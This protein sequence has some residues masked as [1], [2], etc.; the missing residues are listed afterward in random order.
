MSVN[1]TEE[2]RNLSDLLWN[3]QLSIRQ[4]SEN[5]EAEKVEESLRDF[6]GKIITYYEKYNM[7]NSLLNKYETKISNAETLLEVFDVM[8]EMFDELMEN[9]VKNWMYF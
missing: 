6:I 2:R 4:E 8:K 3:S 1:N 7:N 9:V 5:D